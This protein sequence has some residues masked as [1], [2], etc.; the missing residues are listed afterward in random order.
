[1]GGIDGKIE[2]K[3]KDSDKTGLEERCLTKEKKGRGGGRGSEGGRG[4][5]EGGRGRRGGGRRRERREGEREEERE[6]GRLSDS[7]PPDTFTGSSE[8]LHLSHEHTTAFSLEISGIHMNST[9]K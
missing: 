1:M 4:E 9:N 2:I 5:R 8:L 6:G 7:P 3:F